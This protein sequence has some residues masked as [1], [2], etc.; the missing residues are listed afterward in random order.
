MSSCF[1]TICRSSQCILVQI[2]NLPKI[3][4]LLLLYLQKLLAMSFKFK[5]S[6]NVLCVR[7][8]ENALNFTEIILERI[9]NF[10]LLAV[11]NDRSALEIV[12]G[13]TS[14]SLNM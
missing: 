1:L 10:I 11:E 8:I 5:L 3:K 7:K 2:Q 9:Q 13:L 4:S 12:V 14:K 6:V